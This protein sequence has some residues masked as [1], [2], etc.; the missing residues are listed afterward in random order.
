MSWEIFHG[1]KKVAFNPPPD[2][3]LLPSTWPEDQTGPGGGP[4]ELTRQALDNPLDISLEDKILPGGKVALVTDDG[5]R[6]TP[7]KDMLPV[8]IDRLAKLGVAADDIDII[9][10]AGTHGAM[11]RAGLTAKYGQR[12][13]DDFRIHQHNCRSDDLVPVGRLST[14]TEIKINPIALAADLVIGLGT[15][16][17][18]PMNGF[19]GGP[20]IVFPGLANYEAI[21]EHHLAWT[22]DPASRFGNLRGNKFYAEVSA[23]TNRA[24]LDFSLDCV[25]DLNNNLNQILFGSWEAVHTAGAELSRQLCGVRYERKADA[26]VVGGYPYMEA[27]QL[28]KPLSLGAMVVKPGGTIILT[29]P[30]NSDFP[31][32]FYDV[33]RK[34]QEKSGGLLAKY[35]V[36]SFK[37]GRLLLEGGAPVDLNCA[38][39]YALVC[40]DEFRCVLATRDMDPAP[41]EEIGFVVYPELGQAIEAEGS[42]IPEAGVNLIPMGSLLP[43]LPQGLVWD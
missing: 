7:I 23:A 31:P 12:I 18:H 25:I 43:L 24:G 26:A 37:S 39:Y 15:I 35:A 5:A 3:R 32:F 40:L 41:L 27:L 34:A 4:T 11:D 1:P 14:G 8:V 19:G 30:S 20:K 21:R 42:L 13:V 38:L 36:D 22:T 33:V 29:A 17:P 10:A 16:L 2:W 6:Q 28:M 9:V